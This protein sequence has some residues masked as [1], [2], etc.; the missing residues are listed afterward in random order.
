V[1]SAV[2]N[3]LK[4]IEGIEEAY[5]IM[6]IY[7][8]IARLKAETVD[9]LKLVITNIKELKGLYN[10]TFLYPN[11]SIKDGVFSL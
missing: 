11:Q 2:L 1:E 7:D 8:V 4:K 9:E 10:S 3:A 6:G 5:N